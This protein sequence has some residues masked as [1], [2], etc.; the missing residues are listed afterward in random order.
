MNEKKKH[1]QIAKN[2]IVSIIKDSII[3]H[4]ECLWIMSA[5][6]LSVPAIFLIYDTKIIVVC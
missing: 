2:D 4:Q 6:C 1:F 3:A 5:S